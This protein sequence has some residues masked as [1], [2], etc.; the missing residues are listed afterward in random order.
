M[1]L[2]KGLKDYDSFIEE[3]KS[4]GCDKKLTEF[5]ISIATHIYHPAAE[6]EAKLFK[7]YNKGIHIVF[8]KA[9]IECNTTFFERAYN[10]GAID[11]LILHRNCSIGCFE[12]SNFDTWLKE[13]DSERFS[14]L[15]YP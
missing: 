14:K 11:C 2:S 5:L 6:L 3:F 1:V 8:E 7:F 15:M 9:D 12:W 10:A 13:K 4:G